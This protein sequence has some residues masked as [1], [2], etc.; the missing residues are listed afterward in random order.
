MPERLELLSAAAHGGIRMRPYVEENHPHFVTIMLQ[1]FIG[2]AASCPIFFAK[3]AATGQFY[4]A[5]LFGFEPSEMLAD[6]ATY[7]KPAFRPLELQ[8]QGFIP[9]GENIAIDV[10]HARFGQGATLALFEDDGT[11]SNALRQ[12]QRVIG[13]FVGGVEA[14]RTFI[15]ELLRLKLIEPI[16]ISLSFDDGQRLSLDGLYTVSREALSALDDSVIITL[17]RA[18]YLQAAL[19]MSMSLGQIALF[20][21]RR[22]A[23][24]T[25][26]P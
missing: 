22:N 1:E 24:L 23:R 17:F 2:A 7:G 16:D 18:G 4:A 15:A 21:E 10:E 19:C 9:S 25:A 26:R 14:T 3:D 13:E 11:P 6:T 5:A 20:A 12:V 8:R